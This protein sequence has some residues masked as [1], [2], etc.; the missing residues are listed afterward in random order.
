MQEQH[1]HEPPAFLLDLRDPEASF[2]HRLL[3]IAIPMVIAHTA[4][5]QRHERILYPCGDLALRAHMFQEQQASPRFEHAPDL[6]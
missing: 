6:A 3:R 5:G 4:G 2:Q 1:G